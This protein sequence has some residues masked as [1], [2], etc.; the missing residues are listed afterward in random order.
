MLLGLL[1]DRFCLTGGKSPIGYLKAYLTNLYLSADSDKVHE[2]IQEGISLILP[3]YLIEKYALIV[4]CRADV[5][6]DSTVLVDDPAKVLPHGQSKLSLRTLTCLEAGIF[7]D[8]PAVYL[9]FSASVDVETTR[10]SA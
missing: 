6:G 3:L 8:C 10:C 4:I 2:A 1:I 9:Q 5:L 7:S